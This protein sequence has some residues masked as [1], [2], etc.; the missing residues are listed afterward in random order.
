MENTPKIDVK[1]V[2]EVP[3][4]YV[5]IDTLIAGYKEAL[6]SNDHTRK[7]LQRHDSMSDLHYA[8]YS[9]LQSSFKASIILLEALEKRYERLDIEHDCAQEG[10]F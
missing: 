1:K 7:S 3:D 9:A 5:L 4:C 10:A 6:N 2:G 8:K